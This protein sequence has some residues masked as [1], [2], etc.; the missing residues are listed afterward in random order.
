MGAVARGHEPA[1]E[2]QPEGDLLEVG[3]GPRDVEAQGPADRV[4]ERQERG[5]GEGDHEHP[6][7]RDRLARPAARGSRRRRSCVRRRARAERRQDQ[8]H[9]EHRDRADDVVPEEETVCSLRDQQHR[10]PYR[11]SARRRPPRADALRRQDGEPEHAQ[12][13]AVEVRP[14]PVHHLDAEP[15]RPACS[16][17]RQ[18]KTPQKRGEQR[19]TPRVV[20][21]AASGARS[22]GRSRPSRRWR[23]S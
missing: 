16:A 10:R 2:R 7:R 18:A 21:G 13:R 5:Q 23:A 1:H 11:R 9:R 12:D 19:A 17:T 20:G 8:P 4:R 15:R 22:A 3:G 6:S 14:E